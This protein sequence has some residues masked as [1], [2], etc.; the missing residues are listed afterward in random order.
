[1]SK[2]LSADTIDFAAYE[3]ATAVSHKVRRAAEYTDDLLAKRAAR[4]SGHRPPTMI[5]TK[6]RGVIEFR[7][8][9]VTAWAG[10]S[11]HRKSMFTSQ[12]AID[13]CFQRQ[14]TLI[15]SMEMLPTETLERM[16]RQASARKEPPE[17]WVR[18]FANWTDGRLW[19]FDHMGR[20]HPK[21]CLGLCRYFADELSGAHVIID[22]MMMVCASEEHT[23]E[24]KQLVTDLCR[25]AQ[26]TGLHIHLV[27][28]A[29]KPQTGEERPPTKYDVRGSAAITDQCDNVLMVWQNKRKREEL[30]INPNDEEWLSKPDALVSVEKQRN[31][32]W[33]G[34]MQ[35]WFDETS[36][37]FCDDRVSAV[38][39]Y[40]L[41]ERLEH[42]Q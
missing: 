34:K 28:H 6:A 37:R 13:L 30:A 5:S 18:E 38:A 20:V 42:H 33:E 8:G 23:D 2:M 15:A 35:F 11:G 19:L 14:P 4:L 17:A 39:P 24:Q 16:M 26:E 40:A 7:P 9:E 3:E 10:Y 22:S 29:R 27:A 32:A 31:G 21:L 1:M 36:L 25:V 12:V 41:G